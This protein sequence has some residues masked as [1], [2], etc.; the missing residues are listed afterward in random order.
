MSVKRSDVVRET[1]VVELLVPK[2]AQHVRGEKDKRKFTVESANKLV[3]SIEFSTSHRA[4]NLSNT[5]MQFLQMLLHFLGNK[6][7]ELG[8]EKDK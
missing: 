8:K 2:K 6:G 4:V 7:Y 3:Q 5:D 1:F